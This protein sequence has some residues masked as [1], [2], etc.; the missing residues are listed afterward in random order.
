MDG[1]RVLYD[2]G[3]VELEVTKGPEGLQTINVQVVKYSY[4]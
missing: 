1:F 2:S 3:K 4:I